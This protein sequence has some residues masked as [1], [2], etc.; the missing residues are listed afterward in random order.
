M[1]SDTGSVLD[2]LAGTPL[3]LEESS[4]IEEVFSTFI[5]QIYAERP[6]ESYL[7]EELIRE[8]LETLMTSN[9]Y[10]VEHNVQ[11]KTMFN[12]SVEGSF[13]IVS[14]QE[15]SVSIITIC[16]GPSNEEITNLG[17]QL[18]T[19]KSSG[20]NNKLYLA[21]DLLNNIPVLSGESSRSIKAMMVDKGMGIALVDSTLII[22]CDNH[23]QLLLD[24]MP[25]LLF[26]SR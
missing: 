7:T 18:D 8:A 16:S 26:L 22:L 2:I 15:S 5:D 21:I 11:Y 17:I 23:D 9:N 4:A 13:D 10:Q 25:S 24:E 19:I 6:D 1:A 14:K 3:K 20:V 12:T